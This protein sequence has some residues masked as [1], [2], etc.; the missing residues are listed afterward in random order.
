MP[1]GLLVTRPPSA[2]PETFT[3]SVY[4]TPGVVPP[5]PLGGGVPGLVLGGGG[6]GGAPGPGGGTPGVA[7]LEPGTDCEPRLKTVEPSA[8]VQA[9]RQRPFC[10]RR[11]TI[12]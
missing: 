12:T 7:G 6:L 1:A 4:E 10:A 11:L 5:P 2:P 8:S 9:I 3:V